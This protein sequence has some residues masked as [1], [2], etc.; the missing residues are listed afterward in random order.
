M[1]ELKNKSSREEYSDNY[2]RSNP[3]TKKKETHSKSF[4]FEEFL[5]IVGMWFYDKSKKYFEKDKT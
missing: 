4:D 1:G 2:Y 3:N 5:E